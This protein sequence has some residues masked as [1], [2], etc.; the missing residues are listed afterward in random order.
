MNTRRKVPRATLEASIEEAGATVSVLEEWPER[1]AL[2]IHAA[3]AR[4]LGKTLRFEPGGKEFAA[5]PDRALAA[6][7]KDA[8]DELH[9]LAPRFEVTAE[10]FR[11]LLRQLLDRSW[12]PLGG[13]GQGVRSHGYG[14]A[15]ADQAQVLLAVAVP[16]DH[17]HVDHADQTVGAGFIVPEFHVSLAALEAHFLGGEE[18]HTHGVGGGRVMKNASEFEEG[19]H[20][21]GVVHLP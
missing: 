2:S 18:D 16:A 21:R 17:V 6:R 13:Q 3:R 9:G 15:V 12:E 5:A 11:L 14:F 1:A 4:E 10:E 8:L 19:G 20:T 7:W